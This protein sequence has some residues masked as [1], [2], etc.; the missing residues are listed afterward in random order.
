MDKVN[1]ELIL[2]RLDEISRKQDE[3]NKKVDDISRK[4]EELT[5]Q[6]TKIKTIE[7]TVDNI[8][9]WKEKIQE[10]ISTSELKELK[11][12]KGKMEEQM[13]V[14]QL[15]QHISEHESFKTFKTQAMMIWIIVQGL[16]AL[17]VFWDDIFRG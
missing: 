2:H 16:M 9:E 10:T 3:F 17:A 6:L 5:L 15:S 4:Q 7:H 11:E 13:S 1:I 12:W 8:K 14:S